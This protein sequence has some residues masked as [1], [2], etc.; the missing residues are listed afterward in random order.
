MKF[1]HRNPGAAFFIAQPGGGSRQ[2]IDFCP[3]ALACFSS[4]LG[5]FTFSNFGVLGASGHRPAG[6][7]RAWVFSSVCFI[8]L[9]G[10][11]TIFVSLLTP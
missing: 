2:R 5:L 6:E 9:L 10:I 8:A 4:L 11:L 1:K 3:P 7:G